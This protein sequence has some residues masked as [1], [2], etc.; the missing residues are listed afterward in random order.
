MPEGMPTLFLRPVPPRPGPAQVFFVV[1]LS[2]EEGG[3]LQ[4]VYEGPTPAVGAGYRLVLSHQHTSANNKAP[5]HSRS[6]RRGFI[7]ADGI[8]KSRPARTLVAVT[9]PS[10]LW[11]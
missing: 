5:S 1:D 7:V 11:K 6:L 3:A 4:Q 9:G 8:E 10:S 2:A